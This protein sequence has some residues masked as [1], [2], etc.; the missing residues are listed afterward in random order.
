MPRAT[1]FHRIFR[2]VELIETMIK[3]D[4]GLITGLIILAPEA[5]RP[6]QVPSQP[7]LKGDPIQ[8]NKLINKQNNNNNKAAYETF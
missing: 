2:N 3:F 7:G 8:N 1:R 6:S 5:E 4:V